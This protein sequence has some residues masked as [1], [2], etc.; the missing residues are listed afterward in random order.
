MYA[1]CIAKNTHSQLNA[2]TA[3]CQIC[4]ILFGNQVL[5]Q[6]HKWSHCTGHG[7][8]HDTR[9]CTRH[10]T[11]RHYTRYTTPVRHYTRQYLWMS[12]EVKDYSYLAPVKLFL[13]LQEE[14]HF[15][16]I[17]LFQCRPLNTTEHNMPDHAPNLEA[18]NRSTKT[19]CPQG[20]GLM[21]KL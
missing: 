8:W 12:S 1:Y 17:A 21:F 5:P 18:G 16:N 14:R 19:K 2:H 20:S 3:C 11:V 6:L 10:H 4:G 7:T 13:R 9:H 15:K